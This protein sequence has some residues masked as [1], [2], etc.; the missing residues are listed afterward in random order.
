METMVKHCETYA[1]AAA[2]AREAEARGYYA[3]AEPTGHLWLLKGQAGTVMREVFR[4]K[5]WTT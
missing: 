5:H 2:L 1:E 3:F 4:W